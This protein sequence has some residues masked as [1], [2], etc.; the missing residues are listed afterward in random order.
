MKIFKQP[1]GNLIPLVV[2]LAITFGFMAGLIGQLVS[3]VYLTSYQQSLPDTNI[4][5]PPSTPELYRV[6]RFLGI[7]QDFEVN[8][9]LNKLTPTVVGVY[10]ARLATADLSQIY[11]PSDLTATGLTLTSDGW[12]LTYSPTISENNFDD[13]VVIHQGVVFAIDQAVV[14]NLTDTVFLKISANNLPVA[15]LGDSADLNLGQLVL[16]ANDLGEASIGNIKDLNYTAIT[17]GSNYVFSTENYH[18]TIVL[19]AELD[20]Y[21][22]GSPVVNLGGEIVGLVSQSVGNNTVIPINQFRPV[23]LDVLR[24][25]I[26]KRSYVGLRY[27]DLSQVKG[28]SNDLTQDQTKGALVYTNPVRNSPASVVGIVKDDIILSVNGQAL[29][30][31]DNLTDLIQQYKPGDKLT[32]GLL[33]RGQSL[34]VEL[35]LALLPE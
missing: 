6:K 11:L 23:I 7:Q 2:V 13:F 16:A 26:V 34:N 10:P 14:D 32:F 27:L 21:Y 3:D 9:A 29:N 28:L 12:I 22:V 5:L 24:S 19:D 25:N 20:G 17:T 18:Q 31:V 30:A 33:R 1:S 35:T 4:N 8:N 15:V